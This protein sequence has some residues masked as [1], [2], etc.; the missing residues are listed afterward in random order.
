ME[1]S[2]IKNNLHNLWFTENEIEIYILI[3]S[4]W[5]APASSIAQRTKIKRVTVYATLQTLKEK[6][7]ISEIIKNNIKSFIALYPE[8][9]VDHFS[10]KIE[11]Q[12]SKLQMAEKIL[13]F[14][15]ELN[16]KNETRPKVNFF[17]WADWVLDI[18]NET[19]NSKWDIKA[20]ITTKNI[21]PKLI[22]YLNS[23]YAK[24]RKK[25]W[26]FAK[27]IWPK[28][29]VT[30]EYKKKDKEELRLTKLVES[31]LLSLDIEV[32]IFDDKVAFLA[33][34]KEDELWV[35][36]QNKSIASSME[37]IFDA[38]WEKI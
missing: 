38:L 11:E 29:K 22:K 25:R 1:H 33:V 36:I 14:L 15:Y 30:M 7:L 9:L 28:N 4:I 2:L 5:Q 19:L 20:F 37:K 26:I 24:L 18:F 3:L 6:W 10:R 31:D 34:K 12:K 21:S 17:E 32:D 35:L 16:G 27:V 8:K 13:P 23:D